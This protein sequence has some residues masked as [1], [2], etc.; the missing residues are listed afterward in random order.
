VG[1]A[2]F[3]VV[4]SRAEA[5][6]GR[7]SQAP[8]GRARPTPSALA[9]R[10]GTV[11]KRDVDQYLASLDEPRRSTLEALR[12]TILE[13]LPEAEQGLSY[14]VPAFRVQ[15]KVLAGFAAFKSHLSYLP[16]SGS[17]FPELGDELATYKT[18][19]GALQFPIDRSLPKPL[20]RKLIAVKRR[21][22]LGG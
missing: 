15:G 4:E 17:V 3:E 10:L 18:S 11:S 14:G 5:S 22:A 13:I 9:A 6:G 7:S 19:T 21:Q 16:H 12:A 20:V 2:R 1:C 8:L